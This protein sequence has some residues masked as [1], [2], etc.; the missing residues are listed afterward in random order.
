MSAYLDQLLLFLL[1]QNLAQKNG[2]N[3]SQ[4]LSVLFLYFSDSLYL[5]K[6]RTTFLVPFSSTATDSSPLQ[7]YT[8]PQTRGVLD[9]K[10]HIAL[11]LTV[12]L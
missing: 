8:K 6:H 4:T 1:L 5:Q 3:L 10:S 12:L 2:G 9:I 7:Q 11:A